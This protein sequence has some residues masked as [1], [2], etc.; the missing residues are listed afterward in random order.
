MYKYSPYTYIHDT[1]YPQNSPTSQQLNQNPQKSKDPAILSPQ[2]SPASPPK[3]PYIFKKTK[4][5]T[6]CF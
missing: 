1:K 5:P 2:N 4:I 6:S 3:Q